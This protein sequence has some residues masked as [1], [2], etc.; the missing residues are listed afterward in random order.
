[1][2]ELV[3]GIVAGRLHNPLVVMSMPLLRTVID[4]GAVGTLR[5]GDFAGN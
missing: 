4:T 2:D 3:A 1:L 5:A